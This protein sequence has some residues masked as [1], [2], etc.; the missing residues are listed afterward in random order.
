MHDTWKYVILTNLDVF[1][2]FAQMFKNSIYSLAAL[3]TI[4]IPQE[5]QAHREKAVTSTGENSIRAEKARDRKRC[6]QCSALPGSAGG[7]SGMGRA[8]VEG[9]WDPPC[10]RCVP[11][12]VCVYVCVYFC[13]ME[14]LQLSVTI[15]EGRATHVTGELAANAI[16]P[17]TQWKRRF[18]HRTS[19]C[20]LGWVRLRDIGHQVLSIFH[21]WLRFDI[22]LLNKLWPNKPSII[23]TLV[24]S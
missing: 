5:K 8:R 15:Y 17:I 9:F 4:N 19:V 12:F 11:V 13:Q 23:L 10:L 14:C 21:F 3:T 20:V 22:C 16:P 24:L 7:V 2:S 18:S 1:Y 6:V